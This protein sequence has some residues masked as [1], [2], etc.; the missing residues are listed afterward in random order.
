MLRS[1]DFTNCTLDRILTSLKKR[2]CCNAYS[3]FTDQLPLPNRAIL[4]DRLVYSG[5]STE[6]S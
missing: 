6:L 1:M 3:Q 4:F 2:S 5:V